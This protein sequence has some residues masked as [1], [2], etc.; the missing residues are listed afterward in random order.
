MVAMRDACP[1]RGYPLSKS[2]VTGNG[3]QCRYHGMTFNEHG[4]CTDIPSGPGM[5]I[6]EAMRVT[7]YPVI[8]KWHWVWIWMGDPDKADPAQIPQFECEGYAHYEHRFYSPMG[9]SLGNF[10]LLHD[11]LCDVTHTRYLHAGLLDD[12]DNTE[13]AVSEPNVERVNERT[14]RVWRDMRNFVPNEEVARLYHL[15]AGMRYNRRLEVWHHF[16]HAVTAFNRYYSY[17]ESFDLEHTGELM[18]EHITALGITPASA[19]T[20]YHF[21]AVSS[22]FAQTDADSDGLLYVIGQDI[23]AFADLQRYFEQHGHDAVE[24]SVP[25]DRL[26]MLSRRIIADMVRAEEAQQRADA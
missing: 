26:G 17:T 23:E 11:N 2:Q 13:M 7:A 9:P 22:S 12:P 25:S 10:Q 3:I 16:P 19:N 15:Q 5:P 1:H 21:T 20:S 24:V 18:V 14:L 8:E 4:S 6:A